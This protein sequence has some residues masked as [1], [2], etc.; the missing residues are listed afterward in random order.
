M[1]YNVHSPSIT[2]HLP[3][4]TVNGLSRPDNVPLHIYH[5]LCTTMHKTGYRAR[6]PKRQPFRLHRMRQLQQGF[7][8]RLSEPRRRGIHVCRLLVYSLILAS[9]PRWHSLLRCQLN[10]VLTKMTRFSG[11]KALM[12]ALPILVAENVATSIGGEEVACAT[13]KQRYSENTFFPGSSGYAYET[14]E[15]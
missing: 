3:E 6:P 2:A 13:L 12:F 5:H 4:K 14:Q 9:V 8:L 15:R 1:A 7:P 11:L 10:H